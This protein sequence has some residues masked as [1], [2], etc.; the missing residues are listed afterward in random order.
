MGGAWRGGCCLT[1]GLLG[2]AAGERCFGDGR[3]RW[4]GGEGSRREG[5]TAAPHVHGSRD[6]PRQLPEAGCVCPLLTALAQHAERRLGEEVDRVAAY[7]DASTEAKVVKVRWGTE[8]GM[9][10]RR[11]LRRRRMLGAGGGQQGSRVGEAVSI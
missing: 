9:R 7:L 6:R 10:G 3:E 8:M 2:G 11:R 4:R 5:G 1:G